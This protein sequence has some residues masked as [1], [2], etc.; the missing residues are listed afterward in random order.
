M[1]I[2][3]VTESFD[4]RANMRVLRADP[5]GY[6]VQAEIGGRKIRFIASIYIDDDK[7]IA[8]I[9]FSENKGKGFT[10]DKTG[11][12]SQMQVFSFIIECIKDVIIDYN[13]DEISFSAEKKD[14]NRGR[15]YQ[16]LANKIPGFTLKSIQ[17]GRFDKLYTYY[18]KNKS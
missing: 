8:S 16:K 5:D 7:K 6:L 15:L 13:P 18:R 4:S 2:I 14:E 12:G 17:D 11:S 3:E 1:K 10:H 9:E